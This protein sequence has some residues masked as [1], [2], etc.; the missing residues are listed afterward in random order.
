ML[1]LPMSA[2]RV[3]TFIEID[4]LLLNSLSFFSS[5][6]CSMLLEHSSDTFA[7]VICFINKEISMCNNR[8]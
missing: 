5:L 3:T 8:Y 7:F 2:Y 4:E 6:F 1:N